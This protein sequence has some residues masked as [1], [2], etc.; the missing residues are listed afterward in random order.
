[1]TLPHEGTVAHYCHVVLIHAQDCVDCMYL[2]DRV[3]ILFIF[4]ISTWHITK[5][6]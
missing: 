4:V 6:Q 3:S 1:M 2:E 5:V